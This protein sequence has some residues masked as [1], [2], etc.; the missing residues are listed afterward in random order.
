MNPNPERNQDVCH[1]TFE[2]SLPE[3]RVIGDRGLLASLMYLKSYG[4]K[5]ILPLP[6]L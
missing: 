4:L 3:I 5:E 6:F 2:S 1:G